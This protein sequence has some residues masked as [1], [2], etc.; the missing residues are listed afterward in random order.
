[1]PRRRRKR[2]PSR[3]MRIHIRREK[4][5]KKKEEF[6]K[7]Q[8]EKRSTQ[9]QANAK[10]DSATRSRLFFILRGR[11]CSLSVTVILSLTKDL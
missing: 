9:G 5:R 2:R 6:K 1:M 4:E 3:G 10:T 7:A 11:K 8:D